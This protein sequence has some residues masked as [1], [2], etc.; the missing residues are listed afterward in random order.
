MTV[1]LL[2]H[3]QVFSGAYWLLLDTAGVSGAFVLPNPGNGLTNTLIG[4]PQS[5]AHPHYVWNLPSVQA[6]G[7]EI[8]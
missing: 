1:L 2:S 3:A 6:S 7:T 8:A 4:D 5:L